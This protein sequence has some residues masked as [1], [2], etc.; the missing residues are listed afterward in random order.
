MNQTKRLIL[1]TALKLFNEKGLSNISL[2]D[3]SDVLRISP[4]N[5]TYHF[6]QRDDIVKALYYEFV[7]EANN[8]FDKIN[9]DQI[10]IELMFHLVQKITTSR[11][12]YL[13][14]MR[15]FIT[16]SNQ[17]P[18]IKKHYSKILKKRSEQIISL[19]NI[20]RE[21]G[22]IK[23]EDIENS[24]ESF[25][26]RVFI[27]GNFWISYLELTNQKLSAKNIRKYFKINIRQIYPYLT[28]KGIKEWKLATQKFD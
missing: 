2:R 3:I 10:N 25:I 17:L 15:D 24:Y 27:V 12:K 20:Y 21:I 9:P 1:D 6:K 8:N 13:F 11:I 22:L 7:E 18:E 19:M 28:A 16:V 14:L 26:E 4:G 23:N 5:L